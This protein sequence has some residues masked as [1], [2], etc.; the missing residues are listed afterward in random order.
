MTFTGVFQMA[1][2]LLIMVIAAIPL[3]RYLS[4]VF[5]GEK[6]FLDFLFTPVEN[7]T[8]RFLNVNKKEETDWVRYLKTGLIIN[9]LMLAIVYFIL[10]FQN[11]LPFNQ[12]RYKGLSWDLDFNTAISFITNTNWQN[13]GGEEVLSNFSQ[14]ALVFLQFTSAATG[15]VFAVAFIRGLVRREAKYVGNF[16]VDFIKGIYRLFLPLAI[17]FAV[18]ML[19]QG[20]PQTFSMQK[21]VTNMTGVKQTLSVG[22]VASMTAIENLGTNGGGFYDANAAQ[23]YENPNPFTNAL[24]IFMM[25][26][27]PIALFLMYGI[28]IGNKK[29]AWTLFAVAMTL[30]VVCLAV[31]Y[32]QEAS[33]NPFLSK[34]GANIHVSKNNPGGNM[35]G[36]QE[37]IGIAQTSLFA[38]ATTAFTTGNVDSAHDSFMPL[39]GMI[40]MSEMMLNLIFGGKGVGLLNMLTMVIIGVFIAGLMVGRTPEFLGK[41]IEAKEV[42]LATLAMFAHAFIILI[43]F[44]ITVAI[45]AGLAEI[46][47][48]GPHGLSEILYAYTSTVANNGSAFAGL[49]GN[50]LF[51]NISLGLTVFFGRYVPIICQ[52]AIAGSLIKKKSIPESAGTFPAHGPLFYAVVMGTILLVG[53]LTFFPALALGPIAEHFAMAEGHLFY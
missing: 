26:T 39:S 16:Y 14:M 13:Y 46:F 31:I 52:V 25:G 18:I 23:P 19:W 21:K 47:N 4:H 36:K 22:P 32:S 11:Y 35:E 24:I 12:M 9:F 10:K 38:T 28:M 7:L 45:P 3:S 51:Y 5:N 49:N 50:T 6:T 17:L 15:L 1:I 40:L 2:T 27:I 33:G 48:P 34:L 41:K 53:A 43:P 20:A 30:I 37:H 42:K 8:F 29:H 44:A